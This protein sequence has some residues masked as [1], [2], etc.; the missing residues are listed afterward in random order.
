MTMTQLQRD[1]LA[2]AKA[3]DWELA[4]AMELVERAAPSTT[5]ANVYE[6]LFSRDLDAEGVAVVFGVLENGRMR[7]LAYGV[8]VCEQCDGTGEHE[9]TACGHEGECHACDGSGGGSGDALCMTDLNDNVLAEGTEPFGRTTRNMEWAQ[10]VLS[11]YR[12]EQT[13]ERQASGAETTME[14]A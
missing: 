10:K 9:C 14:T 8:P 13:K 5:P 7:Y 4:D 11:D 2:R 3:G 6:A 12:T 1:A